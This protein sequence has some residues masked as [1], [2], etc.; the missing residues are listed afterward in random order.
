M[1]VVIC[2]QSFLSLLFFQTE[3]CG[4]CNCPGL[5][6][7][8]RVFFRYCSFKRM[9]VSRP[10]CDS[11]DLLSEF[12]FVTVL[13][14]KSFFTV[15]IRKVVICFQSFLS[16]LFFQTRPSVFQIYCRLWFAFRVFFRYCSFK[17]IRSF[18]FISHSCDLL[19]EFS[20]VTVLSNFLIV[21]LRQLLVV[22][23]FQ[24]FLSLLFFQTNKLWLRLDAKLWFAFR[25]FFRYCSFKPPRTRSLGFSGCDLLSEFSFV[26]VLSNNARSYLHLVW[27]VICF[28]SF[29]SLL[30]F[31]TWKMKKWRASRLWFAFRVF[32]RYCSFKRI[33]KDTLSPLRCDLLSE[34][35][36]VTVLSNIKR[37]LGHAPIVVIC[38]QSFLSLLFFQT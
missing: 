28:Q 24:S 21:I 26:T 14:N 29:L 15:Y 23:C 2:F 10:S 8:F 7:A 9:R 35:S 6:F 19:S 37:S 1:I 17:R 11:C 30:F 16:L 25:V 20:F 33:R 13:S 34:F 32:F 5:W 12:S 31:Q 4:V 38:F 27:V 22:I 36:F 18:S 3:R